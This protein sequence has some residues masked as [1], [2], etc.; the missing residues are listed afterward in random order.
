MLV[1]ELCRKYGM[2]NSTFYKWQESY[3]LF[4]C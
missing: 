4:R 2:D 3:R 1:K